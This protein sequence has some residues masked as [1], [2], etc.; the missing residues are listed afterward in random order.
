MRMPTTVT[1]AGLSWY[2]QTATNPDVYSTNGGHGTALVYA[3]TKASTI[4]VNNPYP[5]TFFN[6]PNTSAQNPMTVGIQQVPTNWILEGDDTPPYIQVTTPI[7]GPNPPNTGSPGNLGV[8]DTGIALTL[9]TNA[10]PTNPAYSIATWSV[11]GSQVLNTGGGNLPVIAPLADG[12]SPGGL[13]KEGSGTLILENSNGLTGSNL[14]NGGTILSREASAQCPSPFGFG[15]VTINSHGSLE[16]APDDS[17]PSAMGFTLASGPDQYLKVDGGAGMLIFDRGNNPSIEVTIGGFT[18]GSE[19]NLRLANSGTLVLSVPTSLSELGSQVQVFVN[20]GTNN[21]PQVIN[22]MVTPAIVALKSSASDPAA[23]LTYNASNGFSIA[24]TTSGDI[25]ASDATT[26]YSATNNQLIT[27]GTSVQAIIVNN[28]SVDGSSSLAVGPQTSGNA[29]IIFNGGT[30]SSPLQFGSANAYVYSSSAGGTLSGP[31]SGT[32]SFTTFGPG[33]LT[34]A[35]DNSATLSGNIFVNSGTLLVSSN[36][37]TGNGSLTVQNDAILQVGG[38]V[39]GAVSV[40]NSATVTLQGGTL[41]GGV[42][43]QTNATL[44]GTGT[45]SGTAT[46]FGVVQPSSLSA[47][48]NLTFNGPS[49]FSG[50]QFF[51][52]LNSLTTNAT[53]AGISWNTLTFNGPTSFA[54]NSGVTLFLDI[55]TSIDPDSTNS[56]WE[57]NESWVIATSTNKEFSSGNHVTVENWSWDSGSFG[58]H[59]MN[60]DSQL[61]LDFTAAPEPSTYALFGLG[62]IALVIVYRRKV[63]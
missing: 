15:S 32:G 57:T 61:V 2:Q 39:T 53:Q 56:F 8:Y 49:S 24:S 27:N 20:G 10:Q 14:I 18:S 13:D 48:G 25:N 35:N 4:T 62:A 30:I 22:G 5:S 41:A 12:T 40:S 63:A 31:V 26:I 28:V 7:L 60:N 1:L 11:T 55:P 52:T 50:A 58:L 16:F 51:W 6:V 3:D 45:I 17:S 23:F 33:T 42:T 36:A 54:T 44:Q 29:G 37:V 21:A 9:S 47:P 34:L 38:T 46:I 43:V 19:Q 59:R